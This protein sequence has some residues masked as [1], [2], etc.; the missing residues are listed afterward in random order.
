MRHV[1]NGYEAKTPEGAW[2]TWNVVLWF[3]NDEP[4]YRDYRRW[5]RGLSDYPTEEQAEDYVRGVF[6]SGTPDMEAKA[7]LDDVNWEEVADSF[8]EDWEDIHNG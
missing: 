7:E 3:S 6:P 8:R 1:Y 4:I 5:L 2:A